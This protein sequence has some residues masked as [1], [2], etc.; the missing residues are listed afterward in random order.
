MSQTVML[1]IAGLLGSALKAWVSVSQANFSKRSIADVILGGA[2]GG[3]FPLVV[4]TMPS[5]IPDLWAR[6]SIIQQGLLLGVIAYA[7]SD[8]IN[9]VLGKFGVGFSAAPLRPNGNGGTTMRSLLVL[10]LLIPALVF[11]GCSSGAV[12]GADVATRILAAVPCVAALASVVGQVSGDPLLSGA[13]TATNVLGLISQIGASNLPGSVMTACGPTLALASQD[14]A[15]LAALLK[16]QPTIAAGS[17]PAARKPPAALIPKPAAGADPVAV[18]IPLR[19][20]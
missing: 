13:V 16:D 2:V 15:G 12:S 14:A 19:R 7:T 8:F 11:A 10:L 18:K 9:N 4:N 3:L 20:R 6:A 1:I 5:P 17:P